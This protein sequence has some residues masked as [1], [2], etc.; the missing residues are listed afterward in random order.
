MQKFAE[1]EAGLFFENPVKVREVVESE[2]VF[3][4]GQSFYTNFPCHLALAG[5]YPL[6]ATGTLAGRVA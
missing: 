5:Y 1:R 3:I 4:K 6:H 2:Y